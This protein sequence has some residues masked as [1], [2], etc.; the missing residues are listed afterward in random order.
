MR[1]SLLPPF[2]IGRYFQALAIYLSDKLEVKE[3]TPNYIEVDEESYYEA[4]EE[5][6]TKVKEH[7]ERVKDQPPV[8]GNDFKYF[9]PKV[10]GKQRLDELKGK[11]LW[12]ELW[13]ETISNLAKAKD[14]KVA[15]LQMIKASVHK[16]PKL[17]LGTGSDALVKDVKDPKGE[18]LA[19]AGMALSV[20]GRAQDVVLMLLPPLPESLREHRLFVYSLRSRYEALEGVDMR[21]PFDKL[22][23]SSE[24]LI[25]F[26]FAKALKDRIAESIDC[27]QPQDNLFVMGVAKGGNRPLVEFITPLMASEVY[28]K[29]K[30]SEN[31][32]E[33]LLNHAKRGKEQAG[34]CVNDLFNYVGS[35][36]PEFLYNCARRYMLLLNDE[37]ESYGAKVMLR[38]LRGLA[39]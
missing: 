25:Q 16:H 7:L 21:Y 38:A 22:P 37:K 34:Q 31:L 3:Y 5:L 19:I 20:I 6:V 36:N 28:C 30:G 18:A 12:A 4:I 35:D 17:F 13:A 26:I 23:C 33:E 24:V 8:Y 10:L 11:K 27:L 2:M 1:I 39:S 9:F 32:L 14:L 15:H 29:L